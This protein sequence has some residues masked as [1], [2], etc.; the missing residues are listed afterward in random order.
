[1]LSIINV[2][3]CVLHLVN[4]LSGSWLGN[5]SGAGI[6]YCQYCN[7]QLHRRCAARSFRYRSA[8]GISYCLCCLWL[9]WALLPLSGPWA[10]GAYAFHRWCQTHPLC[11]HVRSGRWCDQWRW[12]FLYDPRFAAFVCYHLVLRSHY[13]TLLYLWAACC[14]TAWLHCLVPLPDCHRLGNPTELPDE[15]NIW[16]APGRLYGAVVAC[17]RC[18]LC[19]VC[20]WCVSACASSTINTLVSFV[21]S[22]ESLYCLTNHTVGAILVYLFLLCYPGVISV[23]GPCWVFLPLLL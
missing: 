21:W 13:A 23:L 10:A 22:Y 14:Y 9:A 5:R 2:T 11:F 18:V 16:R 3:F 19:I 4:I 8:S 1:M 17:L 7:V 6:S 15:L 12:R 20:L